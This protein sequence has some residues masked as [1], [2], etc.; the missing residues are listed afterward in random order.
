MVFILDFSFY[1][2]PRIWPLTSPLIFPSYVQG[3]KDM[4]L[5]VWDASC[6][7]QNYETR[8]SKV[9]TP[10]Q[11]QDGSLA[12]LLQDSDYNLAQSVSI[13]YYLLF[14]PPAA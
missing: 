4:S 1:W 10:E 3:F 11:L 7:L 9:I 2:I 6:V 12:D 14:S 8:T 13:V 5:S